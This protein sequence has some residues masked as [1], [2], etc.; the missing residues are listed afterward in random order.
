[1]PTSKTSLCLAACSFA[2]FQ[3]YTAVAA[4]AEVNHV[5]SLA[6]AFISSYEPDTHVV[7]CSRKGGRVTLPTVTYASP[8]QLR[9]QDEVWHGIR[10]SV[11]R[12]DLSYEGS[13]LAH[14]VRIPPPEPPWPL[15]A[16]VP[17]SCLFFCLC[18]ARCRSCNNREGRG[19]DLAGENSVV[20]SDFANGPREDEEEQRTGRCL[21]LVWKLSSQV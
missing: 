11:A 20:P 4:T 5:I 15:G 17:V 2:F 13:P 8:P 1:M 21:F 18:W 12:V 7:W 14:E 19:W 9:S 6:P 3:Y 10:G 16:V